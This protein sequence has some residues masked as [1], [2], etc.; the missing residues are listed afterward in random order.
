MEASRR[1][2]AEDEMMRMAA[3]MLTLEAINQDRTQEANL[4]GHVAEQ[5]G[6][7]PEDIVQVI[8]M[9]LEQSGY[10]QDSTVVSRQ[11]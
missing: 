8:E 5:Y 9:C 6:L 4:L 11:D 1:I 10:T 2:A 7:A 3:H